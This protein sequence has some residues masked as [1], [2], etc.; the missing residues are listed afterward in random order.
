M[1]VMGHI[2]RGCSLLLLGASWQ[3][4]AA[5]IDVVDDTGVHLVLPE[6]A[7]RIVSLA[8]GATEMLFAAGAGPQ[9]IAT[10]TYADQPESARRVPRIGDANAIDMERLLILKPQVVVYWP[11]GNNA[12]QIAQLKRL[13]F[14]LYGQQVNRLADL[15]DSLRRLGVMAGTSAAARRRAG[16]IEVQLSALRGQYA[17]RLPVRALLETWNQPLYTVG[18]QQL[19]S[20]ALSICGAVNIFTDV[21]QLSSAVQVEA[22]I[23][24]DPDLI[25]AAAPPGVGPQWLQEWRRFPSMKAVRS[26]NLLDFEDQALSRLGPSVVD[27]TANLCPL[28]DAT[29][30]RH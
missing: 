24:R 8:P 21:A 17:G 20:D 29:R 30:A 14:T 22:V 13:G 4:I 25:I 2:I 10:V 3:A 23:S 5:G 6:P 7:Q 12:A 18:G 16:Q 9:V 11:G 1:T 27:A 15:G 26:G 19:M 28:I